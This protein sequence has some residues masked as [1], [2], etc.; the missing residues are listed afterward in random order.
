MEKQRGEERQVSK[1]RRGA[2]VV[3]VG[4]LGRREKKERQ[5]FRNWRWDRISRE[6]VVKHHDSPFKQSRVQI[7]APPY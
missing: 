7:L 3:M 5:T 6:T 2:S 4:V 1:E